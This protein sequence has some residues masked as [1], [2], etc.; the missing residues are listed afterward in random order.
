MEQTLHYL[1][2]YFSYMANQTLHNF[3]RDL[4]LGLFFLIPH[5]KRPQGFRC[6]SCWIW[7][8]LLN[9]VI[10]IAVVCFWNSRCNSHITRGCKWVV[11]ALGVMLKLK[12]CLSNLCNFAGNQSKSLFGL[13]FSF[14][15]ISHELE[16]LTCDFRLIQIL[17][18]CLKAILA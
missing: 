10:K 12:E 13:A 16:I 7:K 15:L 5:T 8:P 18:K 11:I 1:C 4:M 3:V 14:W 6:F 17:Q 2:D 9:L